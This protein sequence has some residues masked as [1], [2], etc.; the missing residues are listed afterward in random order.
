MSSRDEEFTFWNRRK[1]PKEVAEYMH[2]EGSCVGLEY[3]THGDIWDAP[4]D[5][6]QVGLLHMVIDRLDDIKKFVDKPHDMMAG[7]SAWLFSFHER[8]VKVLSDHKKECE[9]INEFCDV[10]LLGKDIKL[11]DD[12]NS[13]SWTYRK[14]FAD[15]KWDAVI[16]RGKYYRHRGIERLE[17]QVKRLKSVKTIGDIE[18]LAG[19]GKKT[20]AKI[21]NKAKGEL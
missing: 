6:V 3:K 9:R 18:N 2:T 4:S 20:A 14:D 21:I 17:S 19:I 10:R 1:S 8:A 11:Y 15:G 13:L 12:I 7:H 16:L 5:L